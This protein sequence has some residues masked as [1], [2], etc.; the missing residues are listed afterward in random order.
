[1]S[2]ALM[3]CVFAIICLLVWKFHLFESRVVGISV[4]VLTGAVVISEYLSTPRPWGARG[5][6]LW[7]FAIIVAAL[8]VVVGEYY[9]IDWLAVNG[10]LTFTA[11]LLWW[12]TWQVLRRRLLLSSGL[13]L[14]MAAMMIYWG[15][16]LHQTR[17][18]LTFLLAPVPGVLLVSAIW[19]PVGW[20]ILYLAEVNKDRK[21][22]GPGMQALSMA[23][24]FLP[25]LA[26][27]V[28]VPH[29][30]QL[31]EA[32]SAASLTMVGV[33][34]SAVAS[35][36]LRRFL[37][38]CGNLVPR[39]SGMTP[40][41]TWRSSVA[42]YLSSAIDRTGYHR[43][44]VA[45]GALLLVAIAVALLLMAND[46]NR[47]STDVILGFVPDY[48]SGVVIA[49]KDTLVSGGVPKAYSDWIAQ[50]SFVRLTRYEAIG[51]ESGE[52]NTMGEVH[53][54]RG[55]VALEVLVGDF[56]FGTVRRQLEIGMGCSQTLYGHTEYWICP[57]PEYPAVALSTRDRYVVL[58]TRYRSDLKHI[59][60]YRDRQPER[61]ADSEGSRL[62]RI[63]DR[64]P[65]GFLDF[66]FTDY[67]CESV[68]GCEGFGAT[69]Q[70]EDADTMLFPYAVMFSSDRVAEMVEAR[71]VSSH[72]LQ[73]ASA[74]FGVEVDVSDATAEG[75]FVTG[76]GRAD[77]IESDS[78]DPS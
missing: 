11:V 58:A 69:V 60:T 62:K 37:L 78:G 53:D 13:V 61:F 48:F 17:A 71:I 50:K 23:F 24:L 25:A 1:M 34:L 63:L 47:S 46:T 72:V 51:I 49:H 64:V 68:E 36:P 45:V 54:R 59:L 32:W 35:E 65:E 7:F 73:W 12:L 76:I 18:P 22:A 77:L 20:Y 40:K 30:F 52:V 14:A 16:V 66:A 74:E 44:F 6:L 29:V 55:E 27:A 43:T 39:S 19:A 75:E 10:L 28:F 3:A 2:W 26:V 21:I 5:E 70:L 31:G 57:G 8:P 9:R 56:S 67:S 38:E 41:S 15:V 42:G 4:T 33:L